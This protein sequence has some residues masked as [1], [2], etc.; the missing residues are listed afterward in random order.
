MSS[1]AGVYEALATGAARAHVFGGSDREQKKGRL[2]EPPGVC[3]RGWK[4]EFEAVAGRPDLAVVGKL[5][6][7]CATVFAADVVYPV[8]EEAL[9]R[10]PGLRMW[11]ERVGVA[12]DDDLGVAADG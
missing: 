3:S 9:D 7:Y 12:V 5:N 11:P 2:C 4:G 6:G 10:E 1:A 8:A